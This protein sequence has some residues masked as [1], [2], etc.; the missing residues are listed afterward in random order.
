M[1]ATQYICSRPLLLEA[2]QLLEQALQWQR[3]YTGTDDNYYCKLDKSLSE[4]SSM[5]A[6]LDN[7]IVNVGVELHNCCLCLENVEYYKHNT[8]LNGVLCKSEPAPHFTCTECICRHV[9]SSIEEFETKTRVWALSGT[10]SVV[11]GE[12]TVRGINTAFTKELKAGVH[13]H[14]VGVGT[15]IVGSIADDSELVLT[16]PVESLEA[17]HAR[18]QQNRSWSWSQQ[19]GSSVVRCAEPQQAAAAAASISTD[20]T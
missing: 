16:T 5:L 18:T 12:A 1:C 7:K 17:C 2:T 8:W 6:E 11:Q 14:I 13:T 9:S 15:Y 20:V 10:V 4:C 3:S 19:L